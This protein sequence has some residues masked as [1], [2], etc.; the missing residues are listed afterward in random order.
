MF[1]DYGADCIKFREKLITETMK[2]TLNAVEARM[3]TEKY[4]SESRMLMKELRKITIKDL[5]F[6]S[7]W[8]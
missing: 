5:G 4:P 6:E 3:P 8:F 7:F 2:R 1:D